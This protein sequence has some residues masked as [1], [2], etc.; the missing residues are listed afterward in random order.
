VAELIVLGFKDMSKADE[1]VPQ[2]QAMQGEGLIQLVDWARVIRRPDGKIEVRQATNTTGG[3]AVGGALF[4]ALIGL[5]FLMPLAGAAVGAATGAI[6]GHFADIGISDKFIKDVGNEIS[7]GSSA[8]F[9]YVIEVT[10]DKVTERL[11][12]YEPTLLRTSL[13][14]DAEERLR[15]E[16]QTQT[17][18]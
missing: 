14:H 12:P 11:K 4:G 15:G 2:L 16:L 7:P 10:E 6:I 13:S 3:G 18:A 1:V 17:P 9:L 8:L 5:L